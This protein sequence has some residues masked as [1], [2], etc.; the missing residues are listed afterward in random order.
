MGCNQMNWCNGHGQCNHAY[1]ICDCFD[2]WGSANDVSVVGYQPSSDCNQRVCPFGKAWGDMPTGT[3]EAHQIAECS[4]MGHCD[5]TTGFCHCND[6]FRGNSCEYMKCPGL[7]SVCSGHGSCFT[8]KQ[9]AQKSE[10]YPL[11]STISTY[12]GKISTTTWDQDR[13]VG[14][15]CDSSWPVG[16]LNGETQQSEWYGP[17]CS[18]RRCPSGDN[19]RTTVDETNCT[20]LQ[21]NGSSDVGEQGNLCHVDCS[22]LGRCNSTTG[23]CSCPRGLYAPACD[24]IFL[25]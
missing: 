7:N 12:E 18:L 9:L 24:K 23:I 11:S 5:R 2:G 20:G 4:N 6:G 15:L 3:D 13:I 21:E 10:A 17:D 19:P 22:G 16:L 1:G 14:C 8:M 25:R